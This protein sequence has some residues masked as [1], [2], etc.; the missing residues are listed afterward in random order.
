M[1]TPQRSGVA[2]QTQLCHTMCVTAQLPLE[3]GGASGKVAYIDTEGAL[4]CVRAHGA[5]SP[6]R[7]TE[8][9]EELMQRTSRHRNVPPGQDQ[10]C[11]GPVRGGRGRRGGVSSSLYPVLVDAQGVL[12]R[13][14]NV[15]CGRAWSSCGGEIA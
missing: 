10:G 6:C 3:M 13:P 8:T 11:R 7:T 5:K 14:R 4:Y 9:R 1:Y 2:S 12:A 15:I